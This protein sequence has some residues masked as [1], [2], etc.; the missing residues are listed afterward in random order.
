MWGGFS[1]RRC[2]FLLLLLDGSLLSVGSVG[3]SSFFPTLSLPSERK[4]SSGSSTQR[5]MGSESAVTSKFGVLQNRKP[6]PRAEGCYVGFLKH[7]LANPLPMRADSGHVF[8]RFPNRGQ[9]AAIFRGERRSQ[10]S[11]E[12]SRRQHGAKNSK[13]PAAII[14]VSFDPKPSAQAGGDSA[15]RAASRCWRRRRLIGRVLGGLLCASC[16]ASGLALGP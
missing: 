1:C 11:G 4:T 7:Q 15:S 16:L 2:S 13:H 3:G 10:F 8:T 9:R 5:S 12:I 6:D 14:A